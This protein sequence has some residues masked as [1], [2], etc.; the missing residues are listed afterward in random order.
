MARTRARASRAA[1]IG[2]LYHL[3]PF[4]DSGS[5]TLQNGTSGTPSHPVIL[6]GHMRLPL[7]ASFLLFFCSTSL[8]YSRPARESDLAAIKDLDRR[9]AAA[10]KLDDV[11]TLVS[12][13]TDDGV[14]LQPFSDPV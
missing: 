7:L 1:A 10:A 11:D 14:L 9:D 8:A 6:R 5:W 12:L 2:C 13:C 4:E 3:L